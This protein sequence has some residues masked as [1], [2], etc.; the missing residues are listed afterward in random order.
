M[1]TI[2][3]FRRFTSKI[4]RQLALMV[5]RAIIVAVNN[6]GNSGFYTS[7]GNGNP[8]RVQLNGLSGET[9]TDIER[10]QEYGLETYPI[11]GAT[12]EAV[13]LSLDGSRDNCFVVVIQDK[14]YRPTDLSEGD[15]CLYGKKDV[16]NQ[17]HRVHLKANGNVEILV[18][19]GYTISIGNGTDEVLALIDDSLTEVITS[20][21]F[22][23]DT[24]TFSNG[25][26]PTGPPTNGAILNTPISNLETAQTA[27]GNIMV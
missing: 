19:S 27:L 10:F 12:S 2:T 13:L 3:D 16:D 11:P 24:I 20:L 4:F 21:K 22:L 7:T 6:D 8:Q 23:R 9:L 14:E 17:K 25:G 5:G 26:G 1:L 18:D 15:V